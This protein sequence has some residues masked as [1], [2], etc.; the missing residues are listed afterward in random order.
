[1]VQ[2]ILIVD[3]LNMFLRSYAAYPTMSSHGHQM[4]GCIGFLKTL[5]NLT[6]DI[7]PSKIFCVW[8]GG[9]S[10]KRRR[11]Y[12][13]YKMSRKPEKLNRFYE[14]DI[15]DSEDNRKHQMLSL[16]TMLKVIPVCQLYVAD[17][18]GDDVIAH[19]VRGSFKDEDKIIVSSDKDMYQ[20]LNEKTRVFS[21]HKKNFVTKEDVFTE[22]NIHPRNFAIAKALCGDSSDNVP[23]IKGLGFK[24]VHKRF[25]TLGLDEDVLL[26][27]V[28]NYA[29]THADESPIFKRVVD[30]QEDLKR[31]YRLVYLDGGMLSPMQATKIDTVVSTYKPKGDKMA[32]VKL[33][34]QEGINDFDVSTFFFAFNSIMTENTMESDKI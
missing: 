10:T 34:V 30:E 26:Q 8:E 27:D 16:L 5:K 7:K 29:T 22:F 15:P 2:P 21:P 1:M 28:I 6:Y 23:G 24:T 25:H 12:P 18:E 31:N 14:D 13:E 9:G 32:L 4:G 17:C 33:L 3:V 19:L 11:I 20:L